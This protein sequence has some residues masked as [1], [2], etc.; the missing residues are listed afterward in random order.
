MVDASLGEAADRLAILDKIHRYCRSVDRLDVPVGHSVFHEDSTAVFPAWEGSGRGWID[1]ICAEHRNFLHHS[2]QVTNVI[3]EIDGDRAGS[4]SYVFAT[5]R[6]EEGR[7]E[8]GR[9]EE[10]T[11]VIQVQFWGRYI[12]AW[13]RRDGEW[14]IDRRECLVDFG[15]TA[16]VTPLPP[17]ERARRDRDDPSYSVLKG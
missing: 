6:R 7:R 3:L 9:H 14:A 17:S 4:E 11:K 2:H 8:E 16:E 1:F 10:G 12:D 15:S 5:L 13:S